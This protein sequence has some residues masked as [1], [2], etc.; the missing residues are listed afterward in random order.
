MSGIIKCN[1]NQYCGGTKT[2][3]PA[4]QGRQQGDG[5]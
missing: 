5:K 1:D 2:M 4:Q 3:T